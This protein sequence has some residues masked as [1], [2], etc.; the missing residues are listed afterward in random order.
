M[1]KIHVAF[2][3][4]PSFSAEILESL[5]T[6]TSLPVNISLVVTQ[7][8]KKIG[9]NQRLTAS[10]V[11]II[12]QK[13]TV[14]VYDQ[15]AKSNN[16][17]ELLKEKAID[18]VLLFAYGEIITQN[19]LDVPHYGFWNI[20]PSLLPLY[21]GASP[22]TY[23]LLLGDTVTGI[24]L[25]QMDAKL[26]HGPVI[27]QK[28]I[29][30]KNTDKRTDLERNLTSE[31]ITLVK[32]QFKELYAGKST[33]CFMQDHEQATFTRMLNKQDGYIPFSVIQDAFYGRNNDFIPQILQD[34]SIKNNMIL[35]QK[36]LPETVYN[37]YRALFEWPGIWTKVIIKNEEKRLKITDVILEN[38]RLC[39]NKVQIE[40]KKEVD[41]KTFQAAYSLF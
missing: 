2:F 21:R 7:P 41:M 35:P 18:V 19:L 14:D 29:D 32:Q 10:A 1:K 5:L 34:Y 17:I 31:S 33:S 27:I 11:K 9:K 12:A 25:M 6:D 36:T 8:D 16:L 22:I 23:P 37:L 26:D 3:G 39:I 13:Y 15:S 4:T 30:I 38:K 20:H 24:S 28:K 40:G